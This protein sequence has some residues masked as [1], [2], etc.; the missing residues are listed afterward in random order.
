VVAVSAVRGV[1]EPQ[2]WLA[3]VQQH[4]NLY[5]VFQDSTS[6]I[7]LTYYLFSCSFR[8]HSARPDLQLVTNLRPYFS[9]SH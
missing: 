8:P 1:L 3:R 9:Y 4:A 6:Q 2:P 5:L 7:L